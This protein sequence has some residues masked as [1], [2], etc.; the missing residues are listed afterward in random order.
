MSSSLKNALLESTIDVA[1]WRE[2]FKKDIGVSEEE[3]GILPLVTYFHTEANHAM[4]IDPAQFREQ[5]LP[6]MLKQGLGHRCR[7]YAVWRSSTG[8]AYRVVYHQFSVDPHEPEWELSE[9]SMIIGL[10]FT[11]K[12]L[13]GDLVYA[14]LFPITNNLLLEALEKAAQVKC[15]SSSCLATGCLNKC[16]SCA[17]TFCSPEHR[18]LHVQCEGKKATSE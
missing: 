9:A 8:Q 7:F 15:A 16:D 3:N 18:D 10:G 1:Q 4:S 13:G 17:A 5:E 2:V 12:M 6:S 11:G 14:E